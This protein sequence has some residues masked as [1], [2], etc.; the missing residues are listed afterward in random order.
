MQTSFGLRSVQERLICR[1]ERA[2]IEKHSISSK[3][4]FQG[5]GAHKKQ[6]TNNDIFFD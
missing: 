5:E 2:A 1:Q 6:E 3:I 4:V